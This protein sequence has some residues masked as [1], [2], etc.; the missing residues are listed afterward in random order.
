MK[1]YTGQPLDTFPQDG[2][3]PTLTV[4]QFA[5]LDLR[6]L[7]RDRGIVIT[8]VPIL[9]RITLKRTTKALRF[10]WV[11]KDLRMPPQAQHLRRLMRDALLAAGDVRRQAGIK[12]AA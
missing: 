5:E 2:D 4:P 10:N 3:P 6:T 11:A 8:Q 7:P 9:G 12:I 1:P